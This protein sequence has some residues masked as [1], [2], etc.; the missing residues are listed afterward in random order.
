VLALPAGAGLPL[1]MA[2]IRQKEKAQNNDFMLRLCLTTSQM[3]VHHH[4]HMG[5]TGSK[6]YSRRK[7]APVIN[8]FLNGTVV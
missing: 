7:G 1:K 5:V 3:P 6:K 8:E 4:G 2:R